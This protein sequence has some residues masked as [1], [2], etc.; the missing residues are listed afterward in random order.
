MRITNFEP[1]SVRSL[2]L[3]V[4]GIFLIYS[5]SEFKKNMKMTFCFFFAKNLRISTIMLFIKSKKK[6]FELSDN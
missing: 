6:P 5:S 1:D 2:N 3:S 4:F